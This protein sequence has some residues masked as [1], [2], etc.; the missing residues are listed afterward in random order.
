MMASCRDFPEATVVFYQHLR[1]RRME[2]DQTAEDSC[3]N[4]VHQKRWLRCR[5]IQSTVVGADNAAIWKSQNGFDTAT[6]VMYVGYI[7][8]SQPA[9]RM[10]LPLMSM[11]CGTC[12]PGLVCAA[13]IATEQRHSHSDKLPASSSTILQSSS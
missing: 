11:I 13:A 2:P 12:F 1:L 8:Q 10:C 3:R 6:M 7:A 5:R 4:I 9:A